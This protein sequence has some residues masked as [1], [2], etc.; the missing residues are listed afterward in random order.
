VHG[1][2]RAEAIVGSRPPRA[3]DLDPRTEVTIDFREREVFRPPVA[4]SGTREEAGVAVSASG[5]SRLIPKP[6]FIRP[7]RSSALIDGVVPVV[8]ARRKAS[9]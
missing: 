1:I 3:T 8:R 7:G 2:P 4:P 9:R 5:C 6:Y